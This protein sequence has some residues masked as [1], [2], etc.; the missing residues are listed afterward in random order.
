MAV[1]YLISEALVL[2]VFAPEIDA[3]L[4]VNEQTD[5]NAGLS[6]LV[7]KRKKGID[8]EIKNRDD[9]IA[10]ANT[11]LDRVRGLMDQARA[12]YQCEADGTCGTHQQGPGPQTSAEWQALQTATANYN[13]NAAANSALID[14]LNKEKAALVEEQK[15]LDTGGSTER[16]AIEASTDGLAVHQTSHPA[17]GWLLREEAFRQFQSDNE[18]NGTVQTI[19]WVIRG[20]LLL[21]DLLPISVKLLNSHTLYGRRVRE[22]AELE[23]YLARAQHTERLA[24]AEKTMMLDAFISS[25]EHSIA[26]EKQKRFHETRTD[27]V[28]RR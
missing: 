5:Y 18:H 10:Q 4:A 25:V 16:A 26:F 19:P 15:N 28:Q 14:T 12:N 7:E 6:V 23:R 22:Q 8:G 24:E 17:R 27:N 2:Q 20:L 3:K 11:E 9:R 21:I 1:A 13:N